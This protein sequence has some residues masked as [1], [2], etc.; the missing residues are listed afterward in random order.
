[1][2][3]MT[4]SLYSL[5]PRYGMTVLAAILSSFAS[6]GMTT[7]PFGQIPSHNFLLFD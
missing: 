2:L 1:M 6:L 7:I 4:I 3:R 5:F